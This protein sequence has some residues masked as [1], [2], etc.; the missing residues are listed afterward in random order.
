ML[1]VKIELEKKKS[2]KE[3]IFFNKIFDIKN[4]KFNK[5]IF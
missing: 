4:Y 1:F 3:N 2:I 5:I